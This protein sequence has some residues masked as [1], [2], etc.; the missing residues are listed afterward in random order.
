MKRALAYG[1]MVWLIPFAVSVLI[2]KLRDSNR[3]LFESLMPVA[4]AVSVVFFGNLY[5]R[6][7]EKDFRKEGVLLGAL[8]MAMSIVID[9]PLFSKGPMAMPFGKYMADIGVTYLMIPAITI[10]FGYVMGRR[11]PEG[12]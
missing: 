3:P 1:V 2:F 4:V 8:W 10:G 12:G 5:F 9:L 11:I 6:K 7:L